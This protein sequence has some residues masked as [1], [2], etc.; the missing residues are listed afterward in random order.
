MASRKHATPRT[1][2][3]LELEPLPGINP[4]KSLRW[5][6][7]RLLRAYGLKCTNIHETSTQD[8]HAHPSPARE[9]EIYWGDMKDKETEQMLF[10]EQER[11]RFRRHATKMQTSTLP[12]LTYRDGVFRLSGEEEPEG[13]TW[14]ALT[15]KIVVGW[16]LFIDNKVAEAHTWLLRDLDGNPPRPDTF[17]DKQQWKLGP[18]GKPSDPWSFQYTLFIMDEVTKRV[19]E[20]KASTIDTRAAVARLMEDFQKTAR[21]PVV[22]LSVKVNPTNINA[23]MPDLEIV[24]YSDN[25]Q[26]E[27][28]GLVITLRDDTPVSDFNGGM[29][30]D[31]IPW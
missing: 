31:K 12:F 27:I 30:N 7:K 1:R 9:P 15:D 21:R 5:S 19:V 29:K 10:T 16:Y 23:M 17:T 18:S 13:S 14:V 25:E 22:V 4:I 8:L 28:P 6:L 20:F 3:V 2:F 11:E 26:E 24:G